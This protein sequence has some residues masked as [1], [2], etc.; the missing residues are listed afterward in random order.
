MNVLITSNDKQYISGLQAL[1]DEHHVDSVVASSGEEALHLL[2]GDFKAVVSDVLLP[3]MDGFDLC[4]A[5]K[6]DS[7]TSCIPFVLCA[8]VQTLNPILDRT[9]AASAGADAYL[10]SAHEEP[11]VEVLETLVRQGVRPSEHMP[12]SPGGDDIT[13]SHHH[14]EWRASIDKE[15]ENSA[16]VDSAARATGP[17]RDI[18][19]I[20]YE[21]APIGYFSLDRHGVI[22]EVNK[23]GTR[24]LGM[25]REGL[26]GVPLEEYVTP[27]NRK[28]LH[29]H[30]DAVF[31]SGEIQVCEIAIFSASAGKRCAHLQ[32][33]AR[34]DRHGQA[35]CLVSMID[36]TERKRR[37]ED[38]RFLS[39]ANRRLAQSIDYQTTLAQLARM[40]V[41]Y[42]A[43][44]CTVFIIEQ[45]GSIQRLAMAHAD[46]AKE[47]IASE[48]QRRFPIG[49]ENPFAVPVL[50]G[51]TVL[52]PELG[53]EQMAN[54]TSSKEHLELVRRLGPTS[55]MII[56]L[57]AHGRILGALSLMATGTHPNYDREDLELATE[58]AR[59]AAMPIENARLYKEAQEAVKARDEFLS[60]AS[61]E[62]RTPLTSLTLQLQSLMKGIR[63]NGLRNMS[64]DRV[65][66][67]LEGAYEQTQRMTRL[68]DKLLDVSR[69]SMGRVELDIEDVDL[70]EIT[71]QVL[72]RFEH[73]L[74]LAGCALA[75]E[76]FSRPVCRADRFR[77]D[78]VITNLM[79]NAIK[80]GR[81]TPIQ[82]EV[83]QEGAVARLLVKDQGIGIAKENQQRIFERFERA[84]VGGSYAGMGL[85]LYISKRLI[86]AMGGRI[87][88]I[89][90]LDRGSTFEVELPAASAGSVEC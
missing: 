4:R 17:Q 34:H 13:Y 67:R 84:T 82:V 5:V 52:M 29:K 44:W 18:Y 24:M 54:T 28:S 85:G 76:I 69:I 40:C 87:G 74:R 50:Q 56:P 58:L 57:R 61:H 25:N 3:G 27:S 16:G 62:L 23:E 15:M 88:V 35:V 14:T 68:V 19:R 70:A 89:S 65:V 79:S 1:L 38:E 48:L 41:P 11:L 72:D 63:N 8:S 36:V 42:L 49:P 64:E 2:P 20:L 39:E 86:E 47:A 55:I 12:A 26:V 22:T 21:Q 60:I 71:E 80:Y 37:E 45:D 7:A 83:D 59:R 90:Q 78:Q 46:P 6:S 30:L 33:S 77:M 51:E 53:P 81:G 9:L 43:D 73:E 66:N 75:F 31:E 10:L 32:S